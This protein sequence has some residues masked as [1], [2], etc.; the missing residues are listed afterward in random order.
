MRN[1]SARTCLGQEGRRRHGVFM[2]TASA[3]CIRHQVALIKRPAGK[4]GKGGGA[5]FTKIH[6]HPG[7]ASNDGRRLQMAQW[8]GAMLLGTWKE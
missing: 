1:A 8:G 2:A 3:E 7:V 6:S 4:A 5:N